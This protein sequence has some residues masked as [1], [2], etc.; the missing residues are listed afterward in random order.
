MPL[1]WNSCPPLIRVCLLLEVVTNSLILQDDYGHIL[2]TLTPLSVGTSTPPV[3]SSILMITD[4][5]QC[6]PAALRRRLGVTTVLWLHP[7]HHRP[8]GLHPRLASLRLLLPQQRCLYIVWLHRLLWSPL[9][10]RWRQHRPRPICAASISEDATVHWV[11]DDIIRPAVLCFGNGGASRPCTASD[12]RTGSDANRPA[13]TADLRTGSGA[14][15]VRAGSGAPALRDR[16]ETSRQSTQDIPDV[17]R[18]SETIVLRA[19]CA[20]CSSAAEYALRVFDQG[21]RPA[22][23]VILC[24]AALRRARRRGAPELTHVTRRCDWIELQAASVSIHRD[25]AA[26]VTRPSGGASNKTSSKRR[27]Q[28]VVLAERLWHTQQMMACEHQPDRFKHQYTRQKENI[29]RVVIWR[30]PWYAIVGRAEV[31]TKWPIPIG[32][33]ADT[34]ANIMSLTEI[35]HVLITPSVT[36]MQTETF[37]QRTPCGRWAIKNVILHLSIVSSWK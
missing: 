10:R 26:A 27:L 34:K 4:W 20:A 5:L 29:S 19:W 22:T 15:D 14:A 12:I 35:H 8:H 18:P 3:W 1:L 33:D 11:W 7:R 24:A 2:P 6:R 36:C 21:N 16:S 13:A 37:D 17:S 9:C 30:R 32:C 25:D 31:V 23:T 28:Q